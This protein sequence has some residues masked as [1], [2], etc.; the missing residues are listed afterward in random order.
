VLLATL[1][2]REQRLGTVVH[3]SAERTH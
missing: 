1:A 2:A 3:G